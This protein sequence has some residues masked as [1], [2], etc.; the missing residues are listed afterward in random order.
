M[1]QLPMVEPQVGMNVSFAVGVVELTIA[2]PAGHHIWTYGSGAPFKGSHS[3]VPSLS[4][5]ID[6]LTGIAL[7]VD[8]GS[9]THTWSALHEVPMPHATQT[10]PLRPQ[11]ASLLP[12]W[13]APL[14]Q[15]PAQFE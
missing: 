2:A 4:V 12:V 1:M 6:A 10:P 15:Q 8:V 5:A 14:K 7:H 11:A 3:I 9:L 13:H